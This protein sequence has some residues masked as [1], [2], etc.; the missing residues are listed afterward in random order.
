MD[1][2]VAVDD[3]IALPDVHA[4][5]GALRN[6]AGRGCV[7]P[8]RRRRAALARSLHSQ[9][10]IALAKVACGLCW[11]ASRKLRLQVRIACAGLVLALRDREFVSG[12]RARREIKR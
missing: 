10:D 11:I 8:D 4:F 1:R 7:S 5:G 2:E 3:R 12:N 9:Q 6:L